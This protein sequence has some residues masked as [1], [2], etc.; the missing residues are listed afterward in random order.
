M[1]V[2]HGSSAAFVSRRPR[3][4]R[5]DGTNGLVECDA[6]AA[7]IKA[8]IATQDPEC[9][10][11]AWEAD[12]SPEFRTLKAG[13]YEFQNPGIAGR[14]ICAAVWHGQGRTGRPRSG[15]SH[16]GPASRFSVPRQLAG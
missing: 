14:S 4:L 13:S 15:A 12:F 10:V 11:G 6:G 3:T 5:M 2:P 7:K 1:P 9:A 8:T 16:C